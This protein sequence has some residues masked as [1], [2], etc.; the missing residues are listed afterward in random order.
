MKFLER[1]SRAM[2]M[3]ALTIDMGIDS[4]TDA[5]LARADQLVKHEFDIIT[6]KKTQVYNLQRKIKTMKEQLD[7]K[8]LHMEMLRKKVVSLEERL[9]GRSEL[10]REKDEDMVKNRKLVK[11]VEKYK[12]ELNDARLEI[13]D[14]KAQ[15]LESSEMRVSICSHLTGSVNK[16]QDKRSFLLYG[17]DFRQGLWR[18]SSCW[19]SWRPKLESWIEFERSRQRR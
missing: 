10:D 16:L 11:L 17:F 9:V 3:D 4:C 1:I 14:L 12:A 18:L 15:L 8:D 13:R 7:S 2:K 6:D 19:E 5:I